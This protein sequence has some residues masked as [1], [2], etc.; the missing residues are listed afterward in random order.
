MVRFLLLAFTALLSIPDA[1]LAQLQVVS[2]SPA[3]NQLAPQVAAIRLAAE[4]FQP[5]VARQ[6]LAEV[7]ASVND[8]HRR[9]LIDD[10][11]RA[12]LL[13]A[14]VEVEARLELAP[15]TTTT[16]PTATTRP[17][18]TTSSVKPGKGK[19]DPKGKAKDQQD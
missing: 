11:E 15:T 16:R 8:L 7:R 1:A 6:K 10:D 12:Q 17:T 2:T 9:G 4:S 3:R 5:D 19:A 14:A 13:A 18:P